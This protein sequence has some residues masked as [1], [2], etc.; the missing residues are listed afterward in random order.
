MPP[1]SHVTDC[2]FDSTLKFS[3]SRHFVWTINSLCF[4][5]FRLV[6][7]FCLLCRKIFSLKFV[8]F[9]VF[10]GNDPQLLFWRFLM[11]SWSSCKA[12]LRE[13]RSQT[14]QNTECKNTNFIGKRAVRELSGTRY[15]ENKFKRLLNSLLVDYERTLSTKRM[16]LKSLFLDLQEPLT[17]LN[18]HGSEN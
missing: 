13:N 7:L 9:S 5:S 11:R 8:G 1:V 3:W 18:F 16:N 2:Y 4:V 10:W 6:C 15:V 14:R 17:S 12:L